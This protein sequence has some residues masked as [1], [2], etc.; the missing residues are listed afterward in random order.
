V[1]AADAGRLERCERLFED[2]CI[3][4]ASIR[5]GIPVKVRVAQRESALA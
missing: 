2:F 1:D 3:V 5:Q 4:T